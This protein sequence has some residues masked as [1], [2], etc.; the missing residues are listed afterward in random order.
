MMH[1]KTTSQINTVIAHK[2][3]KIITIGATLALL[4]TGSSSYAKDTLD[5]AI[6]V[7]VAAHKAANIS[8]QKI[9][10]L[11]DESRQMLEQYRKLSSDLERTG[12]MNEALQSR[13]DQQHAEINRIIQELS[14]IDEIRGEIDPLMDNMLQTLGQFIELDSPFLAEEREARYIALKQ[15]FD[16]GSSTISE[17]FRRLL[18]A[19][20]IEADYGRN[21]E[22]YQGN[23]PLDGSPKMVDF[24]RLGRVAL[25]YLTLDGEQAAIWDN[26]KRDWQHLDKGYL[27]DIAYALR[28][29]RKQ[30]PPDLMT[31]PLI[32]PGKGVQ[33]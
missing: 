21:I 29:A 25:F 1:V 4:F 33:P 22:A 6:G 30:L 23:L 18:E 2:M 12:Q 24:L 3:R 28:I 20:Q 31:L 27:P 9:D 15:E 17:R 13:I 26:R 8:Q 14:E 5:R 19:Y 7:E 32:V 10:D 16:K 11:D